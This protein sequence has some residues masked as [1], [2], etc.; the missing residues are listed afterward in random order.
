MAIAE[1][2]SN[3]YDADASEVLINL[4]KKI[5]IKKEFLLLIMVF[6]YGEINRLV[7]QALE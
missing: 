6:Q 4:K 2:I 1:L 7:R 5:T 3:A